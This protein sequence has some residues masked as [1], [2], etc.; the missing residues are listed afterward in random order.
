MPSRALRRALPLAALLALALPATALAN[1]TVTRDGAG[2]VTITS[3]DPESNDILVSDST[4]TLVVQ[5]QSGAVAG[6]DAATGC[7][8]LT[9]KVITCGPTNTVTRIVANLGPAADIFRSTATAAN[10]IPRTLNG[11][12]GN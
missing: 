5:E 6:V 4:G 1:A 10:G 9:A 12:G 7:G 3:T 11:D 8:S 2:V